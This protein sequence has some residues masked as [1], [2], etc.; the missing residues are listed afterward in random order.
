MKYK[1]HIGPFIYLASHDLI[2]NMSLLSK[3]W[4][5]RPAT[6]ENNYAGH[7]VFYRVVEGSREIIIDQSKLT[8]QRRDGEALLQITST[9]KGPVN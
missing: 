6:T 2:I 4:N 5:W 1:R 8:F 7:P 3:I 9:N